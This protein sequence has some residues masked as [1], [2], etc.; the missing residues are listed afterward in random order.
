MSATRMGRINE[1]IQR[2]LAE[3]I[4]TVKVPRV[5]GLI[6]ITRVDTTADLKYAKVFV[7][8]DRE[9]VVGTINLDYRSLYHHFECATYLYQVDGIREMEADF[10]ATL[11]KCRQVTRETL[12]REKW[13]LKWMGRFLKA[14]APLM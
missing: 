10:Q 1:E 8:D 5:Q 6:S 7:S 2:A 11:K 9:A 3:L 14:V 4:R 13:T 12:R